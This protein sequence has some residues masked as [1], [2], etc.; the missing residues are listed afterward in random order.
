MSRA[1]GKR[2]ALLGLAGLA[3]ALLVGVM[4]AWRDRGGGAGSAA[5]SAVGRASLRTRLIRGR[6]PG[7]KGTGAIEG[8]VLD[9]RGAPARGAQVLLAR[10]PD[11]DDDSEPVTATADA[12][13]RFRLGELAA[14]KYLVT[15]AAVAPGQAPAAS[16]DLALAPG[17]RRTIELRLGT[18]GVALRGRVLDSGGG[19]LPGARLTAMAITGGPERGYEVR[20]LVRA[21][22]DPA[23]SY[24]LALGRGQ[25]VVQVEADGYVSGG[26]GLIL[27]ADTTKDFRLDPAAMI[28]GRVLE[29]AGGRPVPGAEVEAR[30]PG[31][32]TFYS[33]RAAA[34]KARKIA[35]SDG[36]GDFRLTGLAAAAYVLEAHQGALVGES[37]EV[38]ASPGQAME[39]VTILCDAS[40]SVAGRVTLPGG[41]VPERAFVS[42][43]T[44]R[45][46][47]S[48]PSAQV[49]ASGAFRLEGLVPG[50]YELEV[51]TMQARSAR[52][53]VRITDRDLTGVVIEMGEEQLVT[54]VVLGPRGQPVAGAR[55]S[56]DVEVERRGSTNGG[57]TD[58]NGRFRIGA[59]ETGPV[60]LHAYQPEMGSAEWGPQPLAAAMAVPITLKLQPGVV[61]TGQ[62]RFEDGRP[63]AAARVRAS[64]IAGG[65]GAS[66]EADAGGDGRYVLRGLRPGPVALEASAP[67][68]FSAAEPTELQLA[69]GEQKTVDLVV[70]VAR[71]LRGRVLLPDGRPAAGARVTANVSGRSS[72]RQPADTCD[73]KGAFSIDDL[74]P[75]SRYDVLAELP[76]YADAR[77][78]KVSAKAPLVLRL[79]PES[80]LAGVVVGPAGRPVVDFE[81]WVRSAVGG[82]SERRVDVTTLH[83]AR[84][85]FAL[86]A[87]P[88]GQYDLRA[89]APDG[90]GGSLAVA[91]AAGEHKRDL[92]IRIEA[93]IT[94]RGRLVDHESGRPLAGV[95]VRA[96][97]GGRSDGVESGADGAFALEDVRREE[98][99]SLSFGLEGRG[100]ALEPEPVAVPA[101]ATAA[102]LGTLRFLRGDLARKLEGGPVGLVGF[103]YDVKDGTPVVTKVFPGMPAA[104]AGLAPG[105][106]L[107][108]VDG[109]P[110]LGLSQGARSYLLRGKPGT[111]VTLTVQSGALQRTVTVTR[112]AMPAPPAAPDR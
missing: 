71:P 54:G 94:V 26:D 32:G 24:L 9:P 77:A 12:G 49:D 42:A 68:T 100:Y 98:S 36:A 81:L 46:M 17:Q 80:S 89:I 101:G 3:I 79:T 56:L 28:T 62:V 35:I 85:A 25:Y 86:R 84:G 82:E 96:S 48:E 90:L 2:L 111:P 67:H 52:K 19:P 93:G 73:D 69:A 70:P 110:T 10:E 41:G 63:V 95:T 11:D 5:G 60:T 37:A 65:M 74:E 22:T 38:R 15:A 109:T 87:L 59:P 33:S 64:Q 106:R 92:R 104:E 75:A 13:G 31:R 76:G 99:L 39:G 72:S 112:K 97:T 1:G 14:G 102:D 29:R 44:L 108:A 61:V 66:M 23:G 16:G 55:V 7:E 91:L 6:P 105:D 57:I 58:G 47:S 78:E 50:N 34:M 18:G 43:R 21:T 4:V 88:P 40:F 51:S 30:E 103:T 8:V 83:D 27:E 45:R 107:L 20:A 53:Q